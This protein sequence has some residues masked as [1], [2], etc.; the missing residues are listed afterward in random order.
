MKSGSLTGDGPQFLVEREASYS[1]LRTDSLR[2]DCHDILL[3]MKLQP[4]KKRAT[5][6]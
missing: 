1:C 6:N 3:S 5:F 2:D 4:S